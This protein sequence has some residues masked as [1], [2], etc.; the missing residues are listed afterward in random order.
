MRKKLMYMLLIIVCILGVSN[1]PVNAAAPTKAKADVVKGTIKEH[2]QPLKNTQVMIKEQGTLKWIQTITDTNG[3]FKTKLA[4]GTYMVKGIKDKSNSWYSTNQSFVV[5]KGKIQGSTGGEINLSKTKKGKTPSETSGNFNG[6]L[7]EGKKGLKADLI[8][9]KYNEYQ[10]DIYTVFSKGNGSFTASLPDG[11]YF[12]FDIEVDHGSYRYQLAFTVND[13]KVYVGDEQQTSISITIPVNKIAG[14]AA[15]STTPLTE[16]T[17]LVEKR[18]E[19]DIQFIQSVLTNKKGEFSL[20]ELADGTYSISVYHPT[21]ISV[22][23]ITVEIVDGAIYIDGKKTSLLTITVPDINVKGTVSD[24]VQSLTNAYVNFEWQKSETDFYMFGTPV[25][26]N[27]NFEYRFPDGQYTI[28]TIDEQN[29]FNRVDIPFEIRDGKLLRNG[30]PASTLDINLPPVSFQGKL[31]ES[32]NALQGAINVEKISEDGT[33]EYNDGVTDE[34]GIYSMRLKDGSY[35]ITNA[36]LFDEGEN[37]QFNKKFDIV[38]GKLIIDGNEQSLLELQIPPVTVHGRVKDGDAAVSY[39]FM[40]ISSS[41]GSYSDGKSLNADGTFSLR[42]ADGDYLVK[43][44]SLDDGTAASMDFAFSVVDGKTYVNGQVTDLLE[45]T[46]PAVTVTGTLTENGNPIMGNMYIMETGDA[47]NPVQAGGL[48]TEDG[49][50]Q[51]RLPDGT[52]KVY[53]IYLNDGTAYSPGTEFTIESGQLYVNGEQAEQLDIAVAPVTLSGTVYNGENLVTDGYVAITSLDGSW[54]A[55]YP[56]WIQNGLYQG[57]L[58]DG[59]YEISAVEDFQ[60][61]TYYLNKQFTISNGKL[62][63]DGNEV[64]SLDLNLAD[65]WQ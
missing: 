22:D 48:T 7:K 49:R 56:S 53:D 46:V 64:S 26:A 16:A 24:G 54:T 9:S 33:T 30:E 50:F 25:D 32:G 1:G 19:D 4:D 51:F 2:G 21:Y 63:V 8:I 11:Q 41:D 35:Q 31:V 40:W 13:G 45:V 61:G 10:E 36:F 6:V 12:L 62:F 58:P 37:L 43:E 20:R 42:L 5:S 18:L 23:P 29:R 27:G 38:N 28:T 17:I 3:A 52:Y 39:G 47:D 44:I 15:D 59:Q 57:R 55:G 14:K 34:N 65:G 60:N